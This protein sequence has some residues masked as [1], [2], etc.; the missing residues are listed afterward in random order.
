MVDK[1]VLPGFEL[2][3][4]ESESKVITTTLQDQFNVR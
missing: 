2:G 3:L 4:S 1:E